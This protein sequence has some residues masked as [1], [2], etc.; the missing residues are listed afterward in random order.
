MD[1]TN[2]TQQIEDRAHDLSARVRPQVQEARQKLESVG[3]SITEYI[4]E[5]PAK[6]LVGAIAVGFLVGKIARR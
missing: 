5:N 1:V 3:E 4:K 6:C 2:V